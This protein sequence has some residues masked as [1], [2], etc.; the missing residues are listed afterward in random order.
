MNR[1][2]IYLHL[3]FFLKNKREVGYGKG[4][5]AVSITRENDIYM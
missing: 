3:Y 5:P 2:Q 4:A 1:T